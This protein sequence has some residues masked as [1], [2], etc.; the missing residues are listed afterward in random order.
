MPSTGT[1][2]SALPKKVRKN[3][4]DYI[5]KQYID[6]IVDTTNMICYY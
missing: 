1:E 6:L 5:Y 3:I 2:L 4:S